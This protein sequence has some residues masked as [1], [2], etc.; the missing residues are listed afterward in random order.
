MSE[1]LESVVQSFPGE[2]VWVRG[3]RGITNLAKLRSVA[4]HRPKQEGGSWMVFGHADVPDAR[5]IPLAACAS[6]PSAQAV[7]DEL[8]GLVGALDLRHLEDEREAPA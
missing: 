5:A 1:Q 4:I 7:V 8:M 2:A 3:S 6:E